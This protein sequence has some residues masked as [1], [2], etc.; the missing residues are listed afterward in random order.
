MAVEKEDKKIIN[1]PLSFWDWLN[2]KLKEW[3]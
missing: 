2:L 3:L 1:K